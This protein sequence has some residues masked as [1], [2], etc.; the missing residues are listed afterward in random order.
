MPAPWEPMVKVARSKF[1]SYTQSQG[2]FSGIVFFWVSAIQLIFI[3]AILYVGPLRDAPI[4]ILAVATVSAFLTVFLVAFTSSRVSVRV[5]V[6]A[7]FVGAWTWS[8]TDHTIDEIRFYEVTAQIVPVLFLALAV[9][10]R[11]LRG[12]A[13]RAVDERAAAAFTALLLVVAGIESLRAIAQQRAQAA[14][15]DVVV[16]ALAAATTALVLIGL[17]TAAEEDE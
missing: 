1:T 7:L 15:F 3:G 17:G 14:A 10:T 9:E 11:T 8:F 6:L 2:E 5:N 4:W 12:Q 13:K 16:A